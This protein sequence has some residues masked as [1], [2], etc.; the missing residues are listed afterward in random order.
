MRQLD[1]LQVGRWAAVTAEADG[2][3][4]ETF[5]HAAGEDEIPAALRRR[6]GKLERLA[7]RCTLGVLKGDDSTDEL[8][9]ASRYGNLESLC[10]LL[11]SIAARE[12]MSP[13]GF[14]GSVH[15]AVPGLVG[16]IRKERLSHTAIAAGRNTLTAG[17][18]E[19]YARLAIGDC[20]DVT[21][22][23]ADFVLPQAYRTFEEEG[24]VAG[25]ALALR[26]VR[27]EQPGPGMMAG[28]GRRGAHAILEGLQK[29]MNQLVV[30]EA[31]WLEAAA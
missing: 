31:V 29:G 3:A 2:S 24:D 5:G 1:N 11:S 23:Y 19:C 7:A 9:F 21:L 20:R 6:M 18:F 22:I 4:R 13:M 25:F 8:V 15:N 10:G 30:D 26:L 17:I 14:S 27:A 28:P 12:P 16:Q